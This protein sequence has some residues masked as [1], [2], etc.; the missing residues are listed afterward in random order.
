[1]VYADPV[2]SHEMFDSLVCCEVHS[3]GGPCTHDHAGHA[4]PQTQ[5]TLAGS[6]SVC[7][8]DHAIV[9]SGRRRIQ[10]LHSSLVHGGIALLDDDIEARQAFGGARMES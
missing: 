8:L 4:T 1:M 3:M 10:N 7:P 6:H 5:Y 9:D 2:S